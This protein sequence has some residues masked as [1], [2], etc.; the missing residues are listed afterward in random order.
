MGAP[1]KDEAIFAMFSSHAPAAR[2]QARLE[3]ESAVEVS[4]RQFH[5][6]FQN[7]ARGDQ[8]QAAEGRHSVEVEERRYPEGPPL[9]VL[10]L[11]QDLCETPL[12]EAR[13]G[14]M[15][16]LTMQ[17]ISDTQYSRAGVSG[18][19]LYFFDRTIYSANVGDAM[20]VVSRQG[21]C[22][23]ISR[24][25]DLYDHLETAHIRAAERSIST[26]PGLVNDEVE[27]CARSVTTI[28]SCHECSPGH[29]IYDLMDM[30][31]FV[32]IANRGVWD[33]VPYRTVVDISH[34]VTRA[35]SP[36]AMLAAQ[37]LRDFAISY[38]ADGSTTIMV[39]WLADLFASSARSRQPT[40]D[41]IVEPQQYR[42]RRKDEVR[43]RNVKWLDHEIPAPTGHVALVFTDIRNSTGLLEANPGMPTAM[44]LHN[45]LLRRRSCSVVDTRSK[46]KATRLCALSRPPLPRY[47]GVLPHMPNISTSHHP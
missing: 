43:D 41:P 46:L 42:S 13:K 39:I 12:L 33:F 40:V 2:C 6:C 27:V 25:H 20:A 21:V 19:S 10:K 38:G 35:E 5:Q 23:E 32:I 31:E 36:V 18:A 28:S 16:S 4:V 37:K 22:Y 17:N 15:A 1:R 11:N 45:T 30:D 3:P 9:D 24:K 26:T 7:A 14:W 29:F 34:T 47:G 8:L 44:R